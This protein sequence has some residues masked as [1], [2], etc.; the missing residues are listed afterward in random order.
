MV[1]EQRPFGI[2]CEYIV[3]QDFLPRIAK[4]DF[5]EILP[6]IIP[7]EHVYDICTR[8]PHTQPRSRI[9]DIDQN[10]VRQQFRHVHGIKIRARRQ[11]AAP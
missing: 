1:R 6:G 11:R 4:I 7:A 9:F 8:Q 3:V 2:D 5:V 10:N